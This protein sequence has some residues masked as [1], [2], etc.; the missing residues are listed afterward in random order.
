MAGVGIR[1]ENLNPDSGL[2]ISSVTYKLHSAPF[3]IAH[4]QQISNQADWTVLDINSGGAF[5]R[6]A[7]MPVPATPCV[8]FRN[9]NG[10]TAFGQTIQIKLTGLD[11]FGRYVEEE[12]PSI[13]LADLVTALGG[14][15]TNPFVTRI[16]MS[17][18]FSTIF[19]AS[20][21][22][23]AVDGTND[24]IGI[25]LVPVYYRDGWKSANTRNNFQMVAPGNFGV[26]S[27]LRINQYSATNGVDEGVYDI[28]SMQLYQAEDF[29]AIPVAYDN[30]VDPALDVLTTTVVHHLEPAQVGLVEIHGFDDAALTPVKGFPRRMR[31]S[32]TFPTFTSTTLEVQETAYNGSTD[33]TA[34][35]GP[36]I[37]FIGQSATLGPHDKASGQQ[38]GFTIGESVSGWAGDGSKV[39]IHAIQ[40]VTDP[41]LSP[42]FI[43]SSDMGSTTTDAASYPDGLRV[44]LTVWFRTTRRIAT[45]V[46]SGAY[47]AQLLT[48]NP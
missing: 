16:Q 26:G 36:Y 42:I 17:K 29:P 34:L 24:S 39:G 19:S 9:I 35:D 3:C 23:S 4:Y 20:Y 47:P 8:S 48:A 43:D 38:A 13:T 7:V 18:V 33:P 2:R 40:T 10:A 25:G 30:A 11:Q 21:K 46:T 45:G 31:V 14:T 12:S 1:E 6:A 5:Q 27:A 32:R 22:A 15:P 28:V 41:D 37:R 44:D